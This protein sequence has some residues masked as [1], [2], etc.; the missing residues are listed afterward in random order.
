V[1]KN[2]VKEE[3]MRIGIVAGHTDIVGKDRGAIGYVVEGTVNRQQ[4][5]ACYNELKN[6][7]C[8]PLLEPEG[9]PLASEIAWVNRNKLDLAVAMHNNAG[10]GD[11]WEALVSVTGSGDRLGA[12]AEKH[13]KALG[14]NSRGIKKK[15][16]S[17]GGNYYGFIRQTGCTAVIFETAF[18]DNKNDVTFIDTYAENKAIG[19]AYARAIAE[20]YG[21]RRKTTSKVATKVSTVVPSK[22]RYPYALPTVFPLGVHYAPKHRDV[23]KIQGFLVWTGI[24]RMSITGLY[25]RQTEIAVRI[26]QQ[27]NGLVVDGIWGPKTNAVA[28]AYKRK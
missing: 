2:S 8:Q 6:Y 14:Q 26:F 10:G 27:M 21:L 17:S 23:R 5:I 24:T 7:R 20:A 18:V 4:A 16:N 1:A 25:N 13:I 9:Y 22:H 3:V 12:V 28:K 15:K 19:I 11:G